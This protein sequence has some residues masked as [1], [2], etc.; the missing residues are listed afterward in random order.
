MNGFPKMPAEVLTGLRYSRIDATVFD[1][2]YDPVVTELL[3]EAAR[4]GRKTADGLTM[5]MAQ[6][7]DAFSHFYRGG[8]AEVDSVWDL[9]LRERLTR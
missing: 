5:L 6:A 4:M 7:R 9:E 8:Y 1:M 2:V 3:A